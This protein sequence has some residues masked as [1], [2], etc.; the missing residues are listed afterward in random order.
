MRRPLWPKEFLVLPPMNQRRTC[1]SHRK[2]AF[3][4]RK[5]WVSI[6]HFFAGVLRHVANFK[7][8][9]VLRASLDLVES[10]C[11]FR[12]AAQVL[13]L[14]DSVGS[15]VK[16]FELITGAL[17]RPFTRVSISVWVRQSL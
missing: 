8:V 6:G 4:D 1:P 13:M 16:A 17:S 10:M 14:A 5:N 3:F 7:S 2:R 15:W 11:S 9:L 12:L